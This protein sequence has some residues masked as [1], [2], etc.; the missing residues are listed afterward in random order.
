MLKSDL[1]VF[2]LGNLDVDLVRIH[3]PEYRD[4]S[5]MDYL[6]QIWISWWNLKLSS[7]FDYSDRAHFNR[8]INV[9]TV[10]NQPL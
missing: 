8:N 10:F 6:V 2:Q 4:A 7:S 9:T 5:W 3:G 1:V